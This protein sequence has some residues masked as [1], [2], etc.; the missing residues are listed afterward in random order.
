MPF[1]DCRELSV[2]VGTGKIEHR[3]GLLAGGTGTITVQPNDVGAATSGALWFQNTSSA[4]RPSRWDSLLTLR[5]SAAWAGI[6]ISTAKS[7]AKT[8]VTTRA[9][10]L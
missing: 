10:A 6:A 1:R 9:A 7:T 2:H 5:H 4:T 3:S 8:K